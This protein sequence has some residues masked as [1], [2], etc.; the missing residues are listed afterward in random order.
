MWTKTLAAILFL[1]LF[2]IPGCSAY[3]AANQP[4]A[5]DLSVLAPGTDRDLVRAELG[6]PISTTEAGGLPCETYSFVDGYSSGAKT[7]RSVFHGAA[8]VFTLGLWE[9]VATPTEGAFN[10]T[11]MLY[12]LC[13]RE[14]KVA[15]ATNL[16]KEK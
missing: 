12:R 2:I 14:N 6:Q 4:S 8:D 16:K 11:P 9:I 3:K 13:Y 15:T 7:A 5:K 1:A 10:G